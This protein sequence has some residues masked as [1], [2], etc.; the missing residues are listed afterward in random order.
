MAKT[1]S[2]AYDLKASQLKGEHT[3]Y[4]DLARWLCQ[5]LE[6]GVSARSGVE[7]EIKYAWALYQQDR[8]RGRN[9]PWPDAADLTS[10]FGSEYVDAL[11]ARLMTTIFTE[12]V[13]TVEGWGQ[14][15]PK[16]PFVEEFHQRAQ[17]DERLQT[18]ADEW[19]LRALVEGVG[20]LEVSEAFEMRRDVKRIRAKLL[21]DP[22]TGQPVMGDAGP[23]LEQD[24][25]GNFVETED[26]TQPS[27][28]VEIDSW[29]P[30]RLGPEYDI[31]PYLD[32][33]SLPH[34]ARDRKEIWGYAKRFWRRVPQLKARAELYGYYD[35]KAVEALGEE[36]ER[37]QL[38][39]EAPKTPQVPDQRGGT[40][41]KEL[42]E[43]QFLADLDGEGERW[44]RATVHKDKRKL[45]R[46]KRDDRTTRYIRFV[47]FPIPGTVD[48]GY[49]VILHKLITVIEEDTAVRN[50][51]AD[52]AAMVAGQPL[53]RRI[54]ALWDPAEQPFGPRSV[55]DVRDMDELQP[56]QGITDVP[57]S[58]MQ[59]RQYTRNDA[60]RAIG[61]NDVS[62]GQETQERR[63]LG[64]V[65]LIAG[66]AEVRMNV[67]IRRVQESLEEL[68]LARHEIWKR[69]L[70]M[71]DRLP[72]MRALV[73][74]SSATGVD[75]SG[76]AMDGT[77]TADL[78]D[79][80][81]WGKPK[82]SVETADL[83]RQRSDFNQM[84]QVLPA[85]MQINPMI[86]AI[87]QTLPA[88][89]SL[90]KTMLKVNR[91]QDVQSFLGSEAQGVF[92]QMAQQQ[93][94]T[95]DPRMQLLMA[96]VGGAGGQAGALGA[97]APASGASSAE[98]PA[99]PMGQGVM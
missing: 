53:K 51:F 11:H 3:S 28:E 26:P 73:V 92:E 18:Y 60:E 83:N 64:E 10:P 76:L 27:G 86:G 47:P 8:T 69:T 14:S 74:G 58:I 72:Q 1:K 62:V 84:L 52:R 96:M 43:V 39:D 6:L 98:P 68:F 71:R 46:L 35:A 80:I 42:W 22:M 95:Q 17:E 50:M 16:A 78:L 79:G 66:Y 49:S 59:W 32:F 25:Q 4:D 87:F 85:L 23:E 75:T 63:T 89:K 40:A 30:V 13:W 97:G 56:M 33:L 15:A 67:I 77:V 88:A 45:L 34:H 61:Q 55:I 38:V 93:Q 20:T 29:E 57:A 36:N 2:D 90:V 70:Q 81:F 12:P 37:A 48:R 41:Q 91:V 82:G 99:P 7:S 24:E 65:Q 21:T 5:E 19:I 31:V 44:Y 94:M 54:G 9:A